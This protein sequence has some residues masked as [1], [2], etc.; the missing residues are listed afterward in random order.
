M[1][2]VVMAIPGRAARSRSKR[3]QVLG[4][5]VVAPHARQDG[6]GAGLDRQVEVGHHLRLVAEGV[7]ERVREVVRV[8]GGEA[9][10]AIPGTAATRR[11]SAAKVQPPR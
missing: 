4:H 9:D 6:V 2:S 7:D 10:R 5:R 1:K 8:A 11:S 3:S